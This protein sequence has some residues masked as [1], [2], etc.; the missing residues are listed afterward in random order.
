MGRGNHQPERSL[1][2]DTGVTILGDVSHFW[3]TPCSLSNMVAPHVAS[4]ADG[5]EHLLTDALPTLRVADREVT[6]PPSAAGQSKRSTAPTEELTA[7]LDGAA[8]WLGLTVP[9][10]LLAALARTIART[11]GEGVALVDVADEQGRVRPA[12][13]LICATARQAGATDVLRSVQQALATVAQGSNAA[14][15]ELLFNFEGA[16]PESAAH[17]PPAADRALE[18]RA[19]RAAG[20]IHLDWWYDIRR[21]DDYTVQE[22]A[23]QFTLS[24]YEMTSDATPPI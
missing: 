13:P 24:L 1:E 18:L 14:V 5:N 22:L 2:I 8:L 11:V 3:E 15:S 17:E 19:Y 16:V 23:E 20:L 12:V 6:G 7:E 9:E 10:M 4:P 21:F